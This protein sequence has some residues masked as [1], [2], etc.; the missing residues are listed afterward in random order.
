MDEPTNH[1]D[2]RM[3][4]WLEDYL[5][6]Y[7]GAVLMVTHDRYFLDRVVGKIAEIDHGGCTSTKPTIPAFSS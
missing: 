2:G 7:K 5:Q 6:K 1:L 4:V 3:V